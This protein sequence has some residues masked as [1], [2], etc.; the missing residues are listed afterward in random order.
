MKDC[1]LAV[2]GWR[3][4]FSQR[5]TIVQK[6]TAKAQRTQ[7]KYD[8]LFLHPLH[9][10]FDSPPLPFSQLRSLFLAPF[11]SFAVFF[12]LPNF[13]VFVAFQQNSRRFIRH[14]PPPTIYQNTFFV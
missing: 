5:G 3:F 12:Q 9:H 1:H 7:R 14:A 6:K 13:S 2:A 4:H 11:A 8:S 10:T